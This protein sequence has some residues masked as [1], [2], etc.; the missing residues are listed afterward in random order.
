MSDTS[1][2]LTLSRAEMIGLL[3]AEEAIKSHLPDEGLPRARAFF[4]LM[5]R[6]GRLLP[7]APASAPVQVRDSAHALALL[8]AGLS[9]SQPAPI[10]LLAL[11]YLVERRLQPP[12]RGVATAATLREVAAMPEVAGLR[13]TALELRDGFLA[14]VPA[15]EGDDP[16]TTSRRRTCQDIADAFP[17]LL[18]MREAAPGAVALWRAVGQHFPG[19]DD[20]DPKVA[21]RARAV[22]A[23]WSREAA[24]IEARAPRRRS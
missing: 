9:A 2:T 7:A 8:D 14:L 24:E 1:T 12:P 23:T 5:A 10:L 4:D 13:L 20:P 15:A 16:P 21:G 6:I 22:R 3:E 19:T 17:A 11:A 18:S